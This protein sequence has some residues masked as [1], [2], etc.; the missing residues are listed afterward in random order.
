MTCAHERPV[1]R[2]EVEGDLTVYTA[3]AQK[4]RLL[5]AL[6]APYTLVELDLVQVCEIDTAGV[7]LLLLGCNIALMMGGALRLVNPSPA[8]RAVLE[9]LMLDPVFARASEHCPTCAAQAVATPGAG[10]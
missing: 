4:S 9:L 10:A 8:V 6:R 7:Q 3:A 2:V 1:R 5:P